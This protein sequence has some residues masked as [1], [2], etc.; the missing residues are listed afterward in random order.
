MLFKLSVRNVKRQIGNYLIYFITVTLIVALIFALNNF[1]FSDIM[2]EISNG[3]MEL[4]IIF[5]TISG[6]MGVIAGFILSY[7]TAFLL[8][9]RKKEFGLYLTLGMTR[10]NILKLFMGETLVTFL[11]SLGL[12]FLLGMG[13]Y[14]AFMA[15]LVNFLEMEYLLKGYSVFGA[16][17]TVFIVGLVFLIASAFSLIYL[18]FTKVTKL[19]NAEKTVEKTS[20]NPVVWFS[21]AVVG[22]VILIISLILLDNWMSDENYVLTIDEHSYIFVLFIISV[23]IIPFGVSKGIVPLFIKHNEKKMTAT[24]TKVFKMRQLSGRLNAHSVMAGVVTFLL[25]FSIIMP[26]IF[27]TESITIESNIRY[28]HFYDVEVNCEIQDN[29]NKA[30][31]NYTFDREKEIIEKYAEIKDY[32]IFSKYKIDMPYLPDGDKVYKT[33]FNSTLI[34]E[35]IYNKLCS[36]AGREGI[37]LNGGYVGIYQNERYYLNLTDVPLVLGDV[38]YSNEDNLFMPDTT[39]MFII[40]GS[41]YTNYLF[42]IPDEAATAQN[43]KIGSHISLLAMLKNKRYNARAMIDDFRQ[44]GFYTNSFINSSVKSFEYKRILEVSDRAVWLIGCMFIALVFILIS[45]AVLAVKLLI[46]LEEDK[47]RYK[48][49]WQIGA[50]KFMIFKSLF[51]QM[52]FYYFIPFLL[53]VILLGPICYIILKIITLQGAEMSML[54]VFGQVLGVFGVILLFYVLYFIVTYLIA[55]RDIQKT[56]RSIG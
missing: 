15:I 24:G 3:G 9:R 34:T 41:G 36:M 12:G 52:L 30:D 2:D 51:L 45:I 4:K 18:R 33:L 37:K 40:N 8:R 39:S 1:I 29:F 50:D 21:L 14:Q 7:I 44:I 46:M 26:S 11:F 32:C 27:L 47:S 6:A 13:V 17:L 49:L 53:P 43:V 28:T 48:M 25:L 42:I 22:V 19:L 10:G 35:S 55:R 38:S 16:L 31:K 54:T 56:L 5:I 20:K 23:I